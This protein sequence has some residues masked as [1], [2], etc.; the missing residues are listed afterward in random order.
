MTTD[1]L[2]KWSIVP[3]VAAVA[4]VAGW[5]SYVHALDVVTRTGSTARWRTCTRARLTA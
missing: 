2:I 1:N 5:V 3:A 4:I